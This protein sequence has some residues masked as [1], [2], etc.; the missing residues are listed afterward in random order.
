MLKDYLEILKFFKYLLYLYILLSAFVSSE[1]II[2]KIYL[3][4]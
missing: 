3:N 4:K 2:C 1:E